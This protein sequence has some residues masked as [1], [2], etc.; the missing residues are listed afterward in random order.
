MSSTLVSHVLRIKGN[1]NT[2]MKTRHLPGM[3]SGGTRKEIQETT[4]KRPEGRQQVMTQWDTWRTRIIW[5][6]ARLRNI[7]IKQCQTERVGDMWR[8]RIILN[9]ARLRKICIKQCQM[10]KV[11]DTWHTRIIWNPAR[12]RKIDIKYCQTESIDD[13]WN[14]ARLR[15]IYCI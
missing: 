15:K 8:T 4:T 14:P 9:P 5:N 10:Q 2:F 13:T 11:G 1:N 7:D 12:L 3:T 6:P